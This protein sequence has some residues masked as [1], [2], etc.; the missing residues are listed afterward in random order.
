MRIRS[1]FLP[2]VILL[3]ILSMAFPTLGLLNSDPPVALSSERSEADAAPAHVHLG[4]DS[5]FAK[6]LPHKAAFVNRAALN[7]GLL[8]ENSPSKATL[9]A[10]ALGAGENLPH[11]LRG[12]SIDQSLAAA[13]AQIPTSPQS[14]VSLEVD[15]PDEVAP[16]GDITYSMAVYNDS[17]FTIYEVYLSAYL[18]AGTQFVGSDQPYDFLEA[19]GETV[20]FWY[21]DFLDPGEF[22]AA[23]F[24]VSAPSTDGA[25]VVN[26]TITAEY[27]ET[28]DFTSEFLQVLADI[29]ET[30]VVADEIP[31]DT[32][33]SAP[34]TAPTPGSTPSVDITPGPANIDGIGVGL[35]GPAAVEPNGDLTYQ[36]LVTNS[37][38]SPAAEVYILNFLPGDTEFVSLSQNFQSEYDPFY[39]AVAWYVGELGVGNSAAVEFTVRV[40]DLPGMTVYNSSALI[41]YGPNGG[42]LAAPEDEVAT[43]ISGDAAAGDATVNL[44]VSMAHNVVAG[45]D[46]FEV[47]VKNTGSD[48]V[49]EIFYVDL[50]IDPLSPI[51]RGG[52]DW[53]GAGTVHSPAQGIEWELDGLGAGAT[54]ILT[55]QMAGTSGVAPD[56][57]YTS[58]SGQLPAG[59]KAVYVYV[60]SWAE[61]EST[62]G[63]VREDNEQDNAAL[64]EFVPSNPVPSTDP[65]APTAVPTP[66]PTRLP[67]LTPTPVATPNAT[68]VDNNSGFETQINFRPETHGYVFENWG[69]DKY[70]EDGDL[71][72]AS[73]IRMFGAANVCQSGSD[74]A[75][76]VLSASARQWRT[77]QLR[78]MQGGH[79][80][81]MAV[82]SQQFYNGSV[83]PGEY[84]S[85][86]SSIRDLQPG[87]AVRANVTEFAISQSLRPADGSS[88][89]WV[90]RNTGQTPSSILNLIRQQLKNNPNDPYVL[91]FFQQGKGGHAVTP[92]AIEDKGNGIFWLYFYDN[93]WPGQPRYMIFNTVRE[94]WVY[95]FAS[96][97]PSQPSDPWSGDARTDSLVLRPTNAHLSSG[98][99][100]P[101]CHNSTNV[102]GASVEN[103]SVIFMLMG[104]GEMMVVNGDKHGVGFDF[105]R[106]QFINDVAGAEVQEWI[107]GL[108][109]DQSPILI[110]PQQ[111]GSEPYKVHVAG[112]TVEQ[113]VNA[114]LLVAGPGFVAGLSALKINPGEDMLITISPDGRDVS[115]TAS[116]QGTFSP[117]FFMALDP[118]DSSDSY[119][120]GVGGFE[121]DAQKKV[122]VALN[123]NSGL[124]TFSDN[125]GETDTY[126]VEI[127]RVADNG[128]VSYYNNNDIQLGGSSDAAM[129]F[130]AWDGSGDIEGTI[131]GETTLFTNQGGNDPGTSDMRVFLPITQ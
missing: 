94:T 131:D 69:G 27:K 48:P 87:T 78:S 125:D 38:A 17:E 34:T 31:V 41:V 121:L 70:P 120:F 91:G 100:C 51:R 61:N 86:A 57:E 39:D 107:G 20:Y 26:D 4:D 84:Q 65:N 119:I 9:P 102:H 2:S 93:N 71:D 45:E 76:C 89:Q 47:T 10:A 97:N 8:S 3:L 15:A 16:N 19:G 18:P 129:N 77:Q 36:L 42:G 60:D 113:A 122:D 95:E 12:T 72:T 49:T 123:L 22:V 73:L 54:A 37:G 53:E 127:L 58:W 52:L 96:L 128:T 21:I 14:D 106:Q 81:G 116:E 56:A 33:T 46:I 124:L 114:E 83:T 6:V 126:A 88:D 79:C 101:F 85:G 7:R 117:D 55:S 32:P 11:R 1:L 62:N 25:I 29:F 5:V 35:S 111:L 64:I 130:G 67:T 115:F 75:S 118:L 105:E 59:V 44:T 66:T 28:P 110:L 108:G 30:E 112:K 80:Y 13:N 109:V 63:L 24:T 50:Y 43:L 40:P 98:W 23:D 82:T 104:E 99:A 103:D 68:P 90:W 92:Y 74:A